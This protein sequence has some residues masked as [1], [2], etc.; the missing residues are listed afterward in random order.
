MDGFNANLFN[1]DDGVR[2]LLRGGE[3]FGIFLGDESGHTVKNNIVDLGMIERESLDCVTQPFI[4]DSYMDS[5]VKRV[6]QVAS[7]LECIDM[8]KALKQKTKSSLPPQY[9][10]TKCEY[11]PKTAATNAIDPTY[12]IQFESMNKGVTTVCLSPGAVERFIVNISIDE[13]FEGSIGKWVILTFK[14]FDTPAPTVFTETVFVMGILIKGSVISFASRNKLT[15]DAPTFIP[16]YLS[17][18]FDSL[19]SVD[20]CKII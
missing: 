18:F 4:F 13:K 17:S 8:S 15:V 3:L 2:N 9:T 5:N 19:V 7:T 11:F 6:I 14:T 16:T 1:S 10:L 20:A 12:N